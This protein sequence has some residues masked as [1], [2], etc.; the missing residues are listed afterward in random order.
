MSR[1][2][3]FDDAFACETVKA[4]DYDFDSLH[5]PKKLQVFMSIRSSIIEDYTKQFLQ[6]NPQATVISLGSG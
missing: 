4:I 1:Q 5:M 6:E 3:I 2:G